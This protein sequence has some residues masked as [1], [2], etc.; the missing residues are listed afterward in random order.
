MYNEALLAPLSQEGR[1]ALVVV[2][3]EREEKGVFSPSIA[4]KFYS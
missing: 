4:R 1:F 3:K 2:M